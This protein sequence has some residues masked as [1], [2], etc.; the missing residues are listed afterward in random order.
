MLIGLLGLVG[1]EMGNRS[2]IPKIIEGLESLISDGMDTQE[3]NNAI[4]DLKGF[5]GITYFSSNIS[6]A[7]SVLAEGIATQNK[8][9]NTMTDL[10]NLREEIDEMQQQGME[11]SDLWGSVNEL[12]LELAQ[13]A[14]SDSSITYL[15]T[16]QGKF[17]ENQ[18]V[19]E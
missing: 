17:V 1:L 5:K 18:E 3:I 8:I 2:G 7:K 11:V 9:V 14:E 15:E 12:E 6:N 10:A 16:L 19:D 13:Q 4:S